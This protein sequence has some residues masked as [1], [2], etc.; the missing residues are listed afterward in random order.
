MLISELG[1]FGLISRFRRPIKTDSSVIKGS[2]DDCAVIKFDRKGYLLFTCDM[3]TQGV[4]FL[5]GD[6]PYLI[7]KKAV[8]ISIS[9]IAACGGKPRYCLIALGLPKKAALTYIDRLAKGFF[10]ACGK[11]KINIAGGDVSSA[12]KL[13]IDVSMLGV[14]KKKDLVLRGGA[15]P[16]DII[17]VTGSL[18]GSIRGKHLKF[19]PRLKEAQFLA[20]NFKPTAMIDISD[21]LTQDLGHIMEESRAG[22]VIYEE[23]IP[24]SA[25]ARNLSEALYMGEDFELL[26]TLS[27]Q[28][29]KRLAL[30]RLSVYKPIGQIMNKGYGLKIIERSGKE[31]PVKPRGFRHF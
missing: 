27:P 5:P 2:G 8:N 7:G 13:T 28:E 23:L 4:D 30:K 16:G 25:Q 9:D 10:E 24:L 11:Y 6:D 15:K 20:E 26:F 29:A 19:G 31:K 14:V 18:G 22:A 17:F 21:G 3:I 12:D 1:E